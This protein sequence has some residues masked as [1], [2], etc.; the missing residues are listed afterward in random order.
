MKLSKLHFKKRIFLSIQLPRRA[1]VSIVSHVKS[2]WLLGSGLN[3]RELIISPLSSGKTAFLDI[4]DTL[5]FG[6]AN[7]GKLSDHHLGPLSIGAFRSPAIKNRSL[8]NQSVNRLRWASFSRKKRN[9]KMHK[10]YILTTKH[11]SQAK[12]SVEF[13]VFQFWNIETDL[14]G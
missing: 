1:W 8:I 3:K 11:G 13:D 7:A 2:H 5:I 14:R 9:W 6:E 10:N 4:C 12:V